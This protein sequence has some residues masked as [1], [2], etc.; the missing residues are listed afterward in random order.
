MPEL[1]TGDLF[2]AKAITDDEVN[3]AVDLFMRDPTVSMFRFASGHTLD[4]AAAVKAH[5]P[6][7]LAVTDPDRTERHRRLMVRN[8]ILFAGAAGGAVIGGIPPVRGRA[9][10]A[11]RAVAMHPLGLRLSA[12]SK[13]MR[14][15]VGGGFVAVR[16]A[17]YI[18]R[19]WDEQAWFLTDAGHELIKTLGTG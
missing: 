17:Q 9:L 8:A 10:E 18:G 12:H 13:A 19:K 6:A 16:P 7:R 1:T 11:L 15:L 14:A 3:A 2:K 5:E 4:L